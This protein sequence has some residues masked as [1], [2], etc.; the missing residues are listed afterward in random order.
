MKSVK[1]QNNDTD[2]DVSQNGG[3][4]LPAQAPIIAEEKIPSKNTQTIPSNPYNYVI[5]DGIKF[6]YGNGA[7]NKLKEEDKPF[8][9]KFLHYLHQLKQ[10]KFVS[11]GFNT[12][13][14]F[15][16]IV[17]PCRGYYYIFEYI[18]EDKPCKPYFD[19]EMML[20]RRPK[21]G[22]RK[23][24]IKW[25]RINII[26]LFYQR[27][28]INLV[29]R[30]I[31]FEDSSG[32]KGNVYKFSLHITINSDYIFKN[33]KEASYIAHELHRLDP[34]FDESVYSKDRMMRCIMSAKSFE[35]QRVMRLV[36]K[37]YKLQT[38]DMK[39]F[40][41]YLITDIPENYK[42][43]KVEVL[44]KKISVSKKKIK[45]EADGKKV[46]VNV[47]HITDD[48]KINRLTDIIQK[49]YHEDTYPTKYVY[50]DEETDCEMFGFNYMDHNECCF[51]GHKHDQI[52][53]YCYVDG[54]CNVIVKCFSQHCKDSKFIVGNLNNLLTDNNYIKIDRQTL[55]PKDCP[56]DE[57]DDF[58]VRKLDNFHKKLKSLCLYSPMGTGKTYLMEYYIRRYG[59]KRALI[60]S[61]RQSYANNMAEKF[62]ELHFINYLDDIDWYKKGKIIVQLESLHKLLKNIM[63]QSYELI[64]LDECES[65]LY[66]FASSTMDRNSRETFDL[67]HALCRAPGTEVL[68]LDADWGERSNAFIKSLGSYEVIQNVYQDTIRT[69]KF[70]SDYE[71]VFLKNFL[72][73]VD[74]GLKIGVIGLSTRKLQAI[75]KILQEKGI[76]FVIH[77]RD[78]SD[79]LK[80]ELKTVNEYWCQFQVVLFSPTISVG[81]DFSVE[82]FDKLF[83]YV[84]PKCASPRIFLQ[85]LGRIRHIKCKEIEAYYEHMS[86]RTDQ[87]I[88][89]YNDILDYYKFAATDNFLYKEFE[90][91]VDGNV[92]PVV[93][94]GLYEQIMIHNRIEDLNKCKEYFMT[95][96]NSLCLKKNYRI[97]FLK[98]HNPEDIKKKKERKKKKKEEKDTDNENTDAYLQKILDSQEIDLPRCNIILGKINTNNASEDEKF[99]VHK[100]KIKHFWGIEDLDMEFLRKYYRKEYILVNLKAVLNIHTDL[101]VDEYTDRYFVHKEEVIREL[102]KVLGFNLKKINRIIKKEK[103]YENGKKLLTDSKFSENY[104]KIRALFGKSKAKLDT[105][106]TGGNL[107]KMINSYL[108]EFGLKVKCKS[109]VK[110]IKG[111]CYKKSQYKIKICKAY[112]EFI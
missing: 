91:D 88:Y 108:N 49:N 85:M 81:V 54:D 57:E 112:T 28:N 59:I 13:D 95:V 94:I 102:I 4:V 33:N 52:G 25:L 32:K 96:L 20:I 5:Q 2:T 6:H 90:Y 92:Y 39:D 19:Y 106:L 100:F 45:K 107:I 86:T 29:K 78:T 62:A 1:K 40:G 15:I 7:K 110:K 79:Q 41:K 109:V 30:D 101:S 89:N 51:T 82:Y 75:A 37:K 67:L 3:E 48:A 103:F 53:F 72:K 17:K 14:E 46:K 10:N 9:F 44:Q 66:Q 68:A 76:S 50:H 69:I 12:K 93:K 11:A 83:A 55:L 77:T 104:D 21:N 34:Y 43:I 63:V 26:R 98:N 23:S 35:D 58:M 27:Y 74:S 84:V 22:F 70:T 60:I 16:N 38:I 24:V 42:T 18:F 36:T 80:K 31:D 8:N 105:N 97:Q 111:K 47:P 65:I 71:D 61:T 99:S 64:I 56:I 87:Y 73:Q